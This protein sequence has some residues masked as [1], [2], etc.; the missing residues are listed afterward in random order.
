[1]NTS[2]GIFS[3]LLLF[4]FFLRITLMKNKGTL[5]Y[6]VLSKVLLKSSISLSSVM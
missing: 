6:I 1:M 3:L 5:Q 2:T 4:F